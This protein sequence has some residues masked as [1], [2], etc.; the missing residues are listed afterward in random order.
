MARS[1]LIKSLSDRAPKKKVKRKTTNGYAHS[2]IGGTFT[3]TSNNFKGD[4]KRGDRLGTDRYGCLIH[5]PEGQFIATSDA[6]DGQIEVT[7]EGVDF[8]TWRMPAPEWWVGTDTANKPSI[9]EGLF[10]RSRYGGSITP[11]PA[12]KFNTEV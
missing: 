3:M 5:D 4:I 9:A 8:S 10:I 2:G 7:V 12:I 11:S 1:R 6:K